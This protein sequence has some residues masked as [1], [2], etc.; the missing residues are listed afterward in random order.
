VFQTFKI[1]SA[2]AN[3][4]ETNIVVYCVIKILS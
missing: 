4:Q 3:K 2:I 1:K